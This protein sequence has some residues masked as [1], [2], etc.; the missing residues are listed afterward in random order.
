MRV[1]CWDFIVR[2]CMKGLR[3][4]EE[5]M[6]G[7]DQWVVQF[8]IPKCGF[9]GM[10]GKV[11]PWTAAILYFYGSLKLQNRAPYTITLERLDEIFTFSEGNCFKDFKEILAIL[12][13]AYLLHQADQSANTDQIIF[14]AANYLNVCDNTLIT[15]GATYIAK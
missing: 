13:S 4:T 10:R 3:L 11:R 7:V 1:Q 5:E 2:Y 6:L 14:Q 8:V 12:K 9:V 15:K